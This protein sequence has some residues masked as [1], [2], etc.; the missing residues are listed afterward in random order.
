MSGEVAMPVW[1][2]VGPA[3]ERMIGTVTVDLASETPGTEYAALAALLREA[4]D[5]IERGET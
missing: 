3:S 2:R 1:L 5:A 4:A